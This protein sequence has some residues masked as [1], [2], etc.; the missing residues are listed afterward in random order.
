MTRA[1]RLDCCRA[2]RKWKKDKLQVSFQMLSPPQGLKSILMLTTSQSLFP[3]LLSLTDEPNWSKYPNCSGTR[4]SPINIVSESAKPNNNLSEIHFENSSNIMS[5][6]NNGETVQV[7]LESGVKISG[8]NLSG[9][10]DTVQFHFHW[11]N[12]SSVPGSEHT[13]DGKR[14][15]MELHIVNTMPIYNRNMTQAAEDPTGI[16][17]LGFFIERYNLL[18]NVSLSKYYRYLGSLTT[19]LCNEAVVW[20]VFKEP[21]KV[22][23][24]L[25]DLFSTTL[26]FND[27]TSQLMTNIYRSK[28][29]DMAAGLRDSSHTG[30]VC[31]FN[32]PCDAHNDPWLQCWFILSRFGAAAV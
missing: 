12:G 13:V 3:A 20:T 29:S 2:E 6:K 18:G 15:P 23:K 4:Q 26:H 9:E 32:L 16:A 8:G 27:S 31:G 21:I 22:S 7:M 28:S 25:I 11:G 24:D 10:Y 30:A 14:Y 17:A 1:V 19:P 5:I